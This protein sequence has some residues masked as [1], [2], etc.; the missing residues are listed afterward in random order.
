M[1]ALEIFSA[2]LDRSYY[3]DELAACRY[4]RIGLAPASLVNLRI[5]AL[6]AD[7][8]LLGRNRGFD[9]RHRRAHKAGRIDTGGAHPV[10]P[11]KQ[12]DGSGDVL[13]AGLDQAPAQ[14]GAGMEN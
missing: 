10:N 7:G 1:R 4:L 9:R 8:Q 2:Y 5:R 11:V 6:D 14:T 3:T 12:A 13:P